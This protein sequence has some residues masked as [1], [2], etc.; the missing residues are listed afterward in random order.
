MARLLALWSTTPPGLEDAPWG[1]NAGRSSLFYWRHTKDGSWGPLSVGTDDDPRGA[2]VRQG[3]STKICDSG[4][5]CTTKHPHHWTTHPVFIG[6]SL[7]VP[8]IG[9]SRRCTSL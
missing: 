1:A 9:L 6:S 4:E 3:F 8:G 7:I 5:F 2:T